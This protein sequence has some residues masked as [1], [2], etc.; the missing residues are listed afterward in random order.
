M[1]YGKSAAELR[2]E[3]FAELCIKAMAA[4][5]SSPPLPYVEKHYFLCAANVE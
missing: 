3:C 4:S 2:L 1:L 5:V